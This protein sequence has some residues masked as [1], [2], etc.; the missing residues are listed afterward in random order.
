MLHL[1][2]PLGTG[3]S[4]IARTI[5]RHLSCEKR[6]VASYFFDRDAGEAQDRNGTRRL[7]ATLALQLAE[8]I[9]YFA[10]HLLESIKGLHKDMVED[11]LL[12]H[13][14]DMLLS[15]PLEALS[16]SG[17]DQAPIVLLIDALDECKHPE[18]IPGI[19]CL[20]SE[21]CASTKMR[22]RCL[23]TSR[24]QLNIKLATQPFREKQAIRSL[25]L[26]GVEFLE[27]TKAD[28]RLFLEK[29][30]AE[31]RAQTWGG[32]VKEWPPADVL[33]TIVELATKPEPLFVYAS[34]LCRF[35][36]HGN[37]P[38][39]KLQVWL[40]QSGNDKSQLS[41]IYGPVLREAFQECGPD[42][43]AMLMQFLGTIVLA[44]T[45]LNAATLSALLD[46][47]ID[48][49]ASW[50]WKLIAVL[51]YPSQACRPIRIR[52]KSFSDFLL[53]TEDSMTR[54]DAT[55]THDMLVRKCIG[56]MRA[57]L[58]RD[59]CGIRS[60]GKPATSAFQRIGKNSIPA[61]LQYA[62][63]YWAH[64]LQL[65]NW[66]VTQD[67]YNFIGVHFLQWLEV[68]AILG[69]VTDAAPAMTRILQILY[70]SMVHPIH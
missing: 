2:G 63:S 70:V 67:I 4:T 41:Q 15:S 64:H 68:L 49:I 66:P 56:L 61:D 52:H 26:H 30:F 22:L 43:T 44:A 60:L 11:R 10:S 20:L 7:F 33:D 21:L 59:I 14:C 28:I 29:Q 50:L 32:L 24:P 45:P 6:V 40:E 5:A 18:N 48:D 17:A 62:C 42:E 27:E 46:I 53:A 8:S 36:A 1:V 16:K 9:P 35:V 13:Q 12:E 69:K 54:V 23:F 25:D 47:P 38:K 3:K 34:T 51:D 57:G 55:E 19:L 31:I 37:T 65:R 58:R 39:R